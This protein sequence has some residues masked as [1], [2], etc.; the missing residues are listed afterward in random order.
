MY[1]FLFVCLFV[2]CLVLVYRDGWSQ[3]GIIGRCSGLG[4]LG[5]EGAISVQKNTRCGVLV[6][7]RGWNELGDS[8]DL[9]LPLP[10]S[11][12]T[13]STPSP[14]SSSSLPPST[15]H[16]LLPPLFYCTSLSSISPPSLSSPPSLPPSPSHP[17]LSYLPP[18]PHCLPGMVPLRLLRGR[19]C[20]VRPDKSGPLLVRPFAPVRCRRLATVRRSPHETCSIFS[21]TSNLPSAALR[22]RESTTF[23]SLFTLSPLLKLWRTSFTSHF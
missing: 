22:R 21:S 7:T 11:L 10:S 13:L 23:D 14:P 12:P 9:S 18:L 15:S 20:S 17:L 16:P 6:S 4:E 8:C 5:E 3:T 19:R 1:L 2:C